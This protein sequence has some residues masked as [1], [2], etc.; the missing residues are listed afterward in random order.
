MDLLLNKISLLE[1]TFLLGIPLLFLLLKLASKSLERAGKPVT[2]IKIIQNIILPILVVDLILRHRFSFST[3]H[4]ILKITET[5]LS[6]AV[7]SFL[8]FIFNH[9]IFSE[10]NILSRKVTLPKLGRDVI[11]VFLT[12]IFG[13]GVLSSIWGMDLGHL[14][15]ALGVSSLI[16]GLALQEPLSNLFHG[17]SMLMA[18]PFQR[19]DWVQIGE[20]TGKIVDF[21]WR[22]VKILNRNNELVIIPNSNIGKLHIKNLSRPNR[23]HARLITI[24]FSYNDDP[25]LVKEALLELALNTEGVLDEPAPTPITFSYDDFYITYKLKFYVQD[26]ETEIQ[27][28]D[29][30]MTSIFALAKQKGFKIPFPIR[31]VHMHTDEFALQMEHQGLMSE[32]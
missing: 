12:I 5:V 23:I 2:N 9:L 11:T 1:T 21:T 18:R 26:F 13:A 16:I 7:L 20:E 22:S 8:I 19:H 3:E 10:N 32:E 14:F 29:K 6:I 15:A 25:V 24:G 31:D 30:I 28:T 17:I 27:I 4:V